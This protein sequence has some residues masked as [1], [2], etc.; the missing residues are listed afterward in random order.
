M[1]EPEAMIYEILALLDPVLNTK[2]SH[3]LIISL[4]GLHG[5]K[6]FVGDPGLAELNHPI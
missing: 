2:L 6:N 4:D 3:L 1:Q 5:L